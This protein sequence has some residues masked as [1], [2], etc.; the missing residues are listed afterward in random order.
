MTLV[1]SSAAADD[2]YVRVKCD[3]NILSNKQHAIGNN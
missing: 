3:D 2:L 1:V